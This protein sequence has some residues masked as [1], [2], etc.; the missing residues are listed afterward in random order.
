MLAR[1]D[2]VVKGLTDGVAFLFKKNKITVVHGHGHARSATARSQVSGDDGRH[3]PRSQGASCSPPAASRSS[4]P[5]LPFDGKH[6]RQLDRG[7]GVRQG[8]AST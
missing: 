5:F 2:E 7:A 8:A 3:E 1:K 4:L 6:D